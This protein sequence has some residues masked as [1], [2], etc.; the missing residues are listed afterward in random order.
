[1]ERTADAVKTDRM[2]LLSL[3]VYSDPLESQAAMQTGFLFEPQ[4]SIGRLARAGTS[5]ARAV[6]DLVLPAQCL[7]C[8]RRVGAH[9]SLCPA[10]WSKLRQ[11][12]RPYC[13]KLG[14]PFAYD[15]GEGAMSAEAIADPPPFDRCRAVAVFDDVSRRLVH[16]LKYRDR[17]DLSGSMAKWMVRA[18]AELV[19]DAEMVIPVPL[20]RWRLWS[21]RFNQSASLACVV[22]QAAGKPFAAGVLRRV[23][24]TRQ[25]VG[26]SAAERDRNV[27]GVFKVQE[28]HRFMIEGRSLL[29]VD[30]VYT[31][32]ATVKAAARALLRGGAKSVDVLVFARV[33]SDAG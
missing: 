3:R 22:A 31:T 19:A 26:L 29:L 7:A 9:S 13:E 32:G 16:G 24:P 5:A 2:A 25:Q 33:V 21:R 10:C 15:L 18:G 6:A 8:G 30:D 20:H 28:N 14:T 23:R 4:V 27:R 11:I 12:E 17:L 1:M